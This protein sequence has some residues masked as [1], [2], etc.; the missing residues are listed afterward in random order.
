MLDAATEAQRRQIRRTNGSG[1]WLTPARG[2]LNCGA[3]GARTAPSVVSRGGMPD[4]DNLDVGRH[5]NQLR[6]V[7][8]ESEAGGAGLHLAPLLGVDARVAA[9]G[10]VGRGWRAW[11]AHSR[12]V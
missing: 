11:A 4:V 2:L 9:L 7:R 1:C 10:C 3:R 12:S 8:A 6:E 5:Q